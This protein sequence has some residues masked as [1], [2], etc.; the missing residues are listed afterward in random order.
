MKISNSQKWI[1][2]MQEE[3]KSMQDNKVWELVLL[4]EG[5]KPTGCKWIFKTK[6]D[7]NSNLE[8]YKAH[9]I[10]KGILKKK[11]LI[12]HR[13]SLQFHRKTLSEQ[14]W[15]LLLILILSYIRWMLRQYFSMTTLKK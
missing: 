1:D 5:A 12:L 3:Y 15:R 10:A 9:L 7:A 4:P 2:A 14:S 13:L 11:A 6:R 8:R